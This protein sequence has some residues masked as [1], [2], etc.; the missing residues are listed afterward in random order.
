METFLDYYEKR[1]QPGIA[2]A[3]LLLKTARRSFS[4]EKAAAVLGIS[5]QEAAEILGRSDTPV[6]REDFLRLMRK[7]TS[8]LCQM[9]RRQLFVGLG[10]ALTQEEVS[11]IYDIE[12][13]VVQAAAKKTG[14]EQIPS[15]LLPLLFS[16]IRLSDTQYSL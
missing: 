14:M 12:I 13:G 6:R 4:M 1:I 15:S 8:P 3:D 10:G 7:G 9:F 5:S 2:A 16:A 11:Y